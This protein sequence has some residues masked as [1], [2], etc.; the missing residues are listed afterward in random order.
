MVSGWLLLL[1]ALLVLGGQGQRFVFV[2]ASLLVEALGLGVLAYGYRA[3]QR[4][5]VAGG[6][7]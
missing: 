7:R 2:A 3:V 1:A 5:P 6:P 4:G